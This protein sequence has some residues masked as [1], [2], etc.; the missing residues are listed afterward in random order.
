MSQPLSLSR[1]HVQFEL[2]PG[3]NKSQASLEIRN[4][5]SGRQLFKIM[6]TGRKRYIVKP[7]SGT[8]EPFASVRIEIFLLLAEED[9]NPAQIKD[10]FC[11]YTI[12]AGDR[13]WDKKGLDEYIA[14]NKRSVQQ[15]LFNTSIVS[16]DES[17]GLGADLLRPETHETFSTPDMQ[18]VR[19][20]GL[21]DEFS[22]RNA[23]TLRK[24]NFVAPKAPTV[25]LQEDSGQKTNVMLQSAVQEHQSGSSR[26]RDEVASRDSR[27]LEQR[28][29][30]FSD[31]ETAS[32]AN[33]RLKQRVSQL[34]GELKMLRVC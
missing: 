4:T 5:E 10:K 7:S 29:L 25:Q 13:A 9:R 23:D 31:A 30:G 3:S 19:S 15:I 11:I 33:V 17:N 20:V 27:G 8:L 26:Q 2:A 6:T 12:P 21:P 28:V 16:R 24:S 18:S 1:S 22:G 34:E 14:A 32:S